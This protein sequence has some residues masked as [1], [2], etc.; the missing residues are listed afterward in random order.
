MVEARVIKLDAHDIIALEQFRQRYLADDSEAQRN[1]RKARR[2][3]ERL[4][5]EWPSLWTAL[6]TV[7]RT[8]SFSRAAAPVPALA[9]FEFM[10]LSGQWETVRAD[11]VSLED[12]ALLFLKY[13]KDEPLLENGTTRVD[14]VRIL[15][16]GR[17][18]DMRPK[19]KVIAGDGIGPRL[20]NTSPH[21]TAHLKTE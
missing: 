1:S 3:L 8:V 15:A 16:P 14:I 2:D 10:N 4:T 6:C 7:A 12:G 21:S 9:D 18:L 19:I 20:S 17:W 13:L 11:T 5:D